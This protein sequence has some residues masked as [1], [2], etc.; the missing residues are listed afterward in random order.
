MLLR[1]YWTFLKLYV[2]FHEIK[3]WLIRIFT[4]N[5]YFWRMKIINITV[6]IVKIPIIFSQLGLKQYV[7]L[8]P[9]VLPCKWNNT[10]WTKKMPY[11]KHY[12]EYKNITAI[13]AGCFAN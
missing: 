3:I 12:V 10:V 5:C 1:F 7:F 8:S 2:K 9:N 6:F 11:R 4:Q 13:K